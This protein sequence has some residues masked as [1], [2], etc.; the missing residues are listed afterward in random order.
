MADWRFEMLPARST[1]MK[2]KGMPR[3]PGRCSVLSR[4][5]TV[6]EADAELMA[7]QV[8]VV[9]PLLGGCEEFRVRQD[10]RAGEVVGE[11]DAAEA[12]GVV[13]GEPGL[14]DQGA[15]FVVE[16]Q[17]GDLG[18]KLKC[19]LSRPQARRQIECPGLGIEPALGSRGEIVDRIDHNAGRRD[20]S[21]R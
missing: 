20:W 6:L 19:L 9:A 17:H 10:Q 11:A 21:A 15:Q 16:G 14:L 1:R 4:W 3:A 8:D 13:A 5:H 12:A 2:K 18:A 7:E